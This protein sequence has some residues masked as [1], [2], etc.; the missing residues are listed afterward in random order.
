MICSP[1]LRTQK[2]PNENTKHKIAASLNFSAKNNLR[3]PS[4]AEI[5][6]TIAVH[7]TIKGEGWQRFRI[8]V[9]STGILKPPITKLR[10]SLLFHSLFDCGH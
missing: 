10:T 2:H 7:P 3:K 8:I 6:P 5:N 1:L 9:L 4:I